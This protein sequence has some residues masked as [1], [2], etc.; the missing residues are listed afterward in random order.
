[1]F[2]VAIC[3]DEKIINAQ[4]EN[5]LLKHSKKA[6]LDIDITVFSSGEDLYR[7]MESGHGFDLI[8][9]D[10]EMEPLDGLQVGKKIRNIMKDYRTEIVYVSGKDG[11]DRQLFD[12]QPLN[13]I[14]KPIDSAFV[15]ENLNLAMLK[16]NRLGGIFTYKK[17]GKTYRVPI[18]DIIYFESVNR[19]IKIVTIDYE[20]DFYG[21]MEEVFEPVA[22]YDFIRIHRSYIINYIHVS[23]FK[24][25]DVIMVNDICLP[26]SQSRRKKVRK[27]QL[28]IEQG[29]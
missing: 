15:I 7:Y 17:E 25:S 12:V 1:M 10:I 16:A 13:F 3:D 23:K 6:C 18:K 19:K 8:Y 26:I 21:T 9:L 28:N 24:Y 5:T 2:R 20:D 22:K 4:I 14:P 27:I 11:Y 29:E